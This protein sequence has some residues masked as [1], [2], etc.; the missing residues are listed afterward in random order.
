MPLGGLVIMIFLPF[1]ADSTSSKPAPREQREGYQTVGT[2][3]DELIES[4]AR[5]VTSTVELYQENRELRYN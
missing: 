4:F 2:M 5:S 3:G 1:P